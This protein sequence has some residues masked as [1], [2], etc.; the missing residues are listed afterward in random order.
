MGEDIRCDQESHCYG[1][2]RLE[3][4]KTVGYDHGR[5]AFEIGCAKAVGKKRT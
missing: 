4:R 1:D 5:G 2:M 3:G